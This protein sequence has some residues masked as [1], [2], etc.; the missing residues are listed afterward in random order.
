MRK[1][2]IAVCDDDPAV[3]SQVKE[4]I[5][6]NFQGGGKRLCLTFESCEA[7]LCEAEEGTDF[8]VVI[9]DIEWNGKERGIAAAARLREL[10]PQTR[11]IYLTGYTEKYVQQVFLFPSNLSG[12]LMKPVNPELLERNLK[13]ALKGG[14]PGH[15][16][17][18]LSGNRYSLNMD[19]IRFLESSGHRVRI[20]TGK[21]TYE[22]WGKLDELEAQFPSFFVRCHKSYLVNL[23][24]MRK[25]DVQHRFL[26]EDGREI[27][28]SKSRYQEVRQAYF[29]NG[30]N[31]VFGKKEEAAP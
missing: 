12:F 21:E 11:V 25:L 3:C 22:M 6:K 1:H 2:I 15:F 24:W 17:F 27:P 23:N 30:R 7:L 26:L 5:E 31:A 10:S 8:S 13:K 19:E 16:T 9:L 4:F 14:A 28:V 20:F 29:Q 18:L